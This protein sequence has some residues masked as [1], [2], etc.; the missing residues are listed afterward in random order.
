VTEAAQTGEPRGPRSWSF[1]AEA[2]CPTVM[3]MDLPVNSATRNGPGKRAVNC[4]VFC[5]GGG[6]ILEKPEKASICGQHDGILA[7]RGSNTADV[8]ALV[9]S[10]VRIRVRSH[11]GRMAS[12][13]VLPESAAPDRGR[14]LRVAL[15]SRRPRLGCLGEGS[16]RAA[17]TC[18]PSGLVQAGLSPGGFDEAG[19]GEVGHVRPR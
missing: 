18:L 6:M 12:A 13:S 2:T 5:L 17:A 14:W 1:P 11:A 9:R 15:T 19:T 10:G 7:E 4:K 16:A 8:G 3:P